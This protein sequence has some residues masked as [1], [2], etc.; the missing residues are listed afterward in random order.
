MQKDIGVFLQE[1]RK[2]KGLTQKEVA[3][4]IGVSDKTVSKWENGNSIP[5]TSILIPLCS[6]LDITVNELLAG[7]KLSRDNFT[8]KAEENIISLLE[9]N[10]RSK[11][12]KVISNTIGITVLCAG[13][14][15]MVLSNAGLLFSIVSYFDLPSFLAIVILSVGIVLVSGARTK[16]NVLHVLAKTLIYVGALVSVFS[17]I[18]MCRNVKDGSQLIANISVILFPLL[19]TVI[20]KLIVEIWMARITPT[21]SVL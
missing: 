5:D 12:N 6:V 1:M 14:V 20:I 17:A 19:Y 4:S 3:E 9:E 13:L 11:K 16:E 10:K 15:V 8:E 2:A 7:E 18:V 21:S